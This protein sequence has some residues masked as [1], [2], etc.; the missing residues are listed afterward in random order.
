MMTCYALHEGEVYEL[1]VPNTPNEKGFYRV[2]SCQCLTKPNLHELDT[3]LIHQNKT[4]QNVEECFRQH[5]MWLQSKINYL[6]HLSRD[7]QLRINRSVEIQKR[8]EAGI[9]A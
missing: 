9:F 2:L 4:Y 3:T 1:D 8:I 6:N 5:R 7:Y